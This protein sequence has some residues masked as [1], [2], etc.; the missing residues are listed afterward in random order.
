VGVGREFY[1]QS[2]LPRPVMASD[3]PNLQQTVF[4]PWL[5]GALLA[6]LAAGGTGCA[7]SKDDPAALP[8]SVSH[9]L[10]GRIWDARQQTFISR[11][12]L[13][14]RI[15][16]A[17]AVLLGEIHVNPEHHDLQRDV[18]RHLAASGPGP[19]VVFEM[20]ESDQQGNIDAARRTRGVRAETIAD[21]TGFRDSG[22]D[23]DLYGPLIEATLDLDLPLVAGNAPR[24]LVRAAATGRASELTDAERRRLGLEVPLPGPANDALLDEIIEG[25]CGHLP[26][27]MAPGLVAAQ[28]LRDAT[29]AD[30][31]VRARQAGAGG[32]PRQTV[33]IA[34]SGH[35][36]HDYGVPYYLRERSL[37]AAPLAISLTEV[38]DGEN[39]PAAYLPGNA[40][41][42]V[43]DILWFTSRTKREDPCEAFREQLERMHESLSATG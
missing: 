11:E 22:W 36:R 30:V 37:E 7:S 29:M 23:W 19:A 35:V 15:L 14:A 38:L 16:G 21:V 41:E 28:R 34:G 40:G 12:A 27:A 17:D 26:P 10:Q 32:L 25:H 2:P 3:R 8:P 18:I 43:F 1:F 39:D 31:M 42:P 24:D 33:L 13:D 6:L 4:R 20:L 9:P 5:S